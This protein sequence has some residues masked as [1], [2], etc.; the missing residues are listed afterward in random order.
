VRLGIADAAEA[1]RVA[2][3]VLASARRYRPGADIHGVL[4]QPMEKGIA[5]V[6]VGYRREAQ[7]GPMVVLAA[8]GVL[9]EIYK[10]VA[11]RSAPVERD[12]ALEMIDEVKS[13]ALARGYRGAARGDLDALAEVIV[14]MSRLASEPRIM[15]AEVNPVLVKPEGQ[16]VALLDALVALDTDAGAGNKNNNEQAHLSGKLSG[17]RAGSE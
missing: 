10:D 11:V 16:G 4:L 17:I 7:S 15:E 13:L 8:G 6:L 5:E 14:A 9:A 1:A 2:D 3:E 12:E